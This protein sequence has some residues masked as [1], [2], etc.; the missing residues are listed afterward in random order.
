MK[1]ALTILL[2]ITFSVLV[3]HGCVALSKSEWVKKYQCVNR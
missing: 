3:A 1:P 2:L